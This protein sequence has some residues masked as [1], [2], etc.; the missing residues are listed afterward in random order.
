MRVLVQR[1]REASVTVD[2]RVTGAV[3]RGLLILAGVADD[4]TDTDRDWLVHKIVNLRVFDDAAG[5]MNQSVRDV[6]GDILAV[7][8]FTLY[9]S[10]KKGHRPSWSGA[11]RPEVAAP[12]FAAFVAALSAALGRPVPTGVFGATMAVALVNDGP[13]TLL[14]DSRVRE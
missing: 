1:V 5:V 10:T 12:R 7:S 8:Q 3:G 2:G 9:A 11:A 13:V 14:L 4:D 6:G